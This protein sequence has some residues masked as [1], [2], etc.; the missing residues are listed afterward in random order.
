MGTIVE[1]L[2]WRGD[3]TAAQIP[4]GNVDYLILACLSYARL[5]GIVP[6]IGEGEITIQEAAALYRSAY[7]D[8]RNRTSTILTENIPKILLQ[9]AETRRFGSLRLRNYCHLRDLG[10]AV[11]FSA[12][13]ILQEDGT[14]CISFG[15]TDTSLAG[16]KEDL[17]LSYEVVPA[18]V[19][20]AAYLDTIHAGRQEPILLVGH[21]KGGHLAIYAAAAC[22]EEIRSRITRIFD[23]DGPGFGRGMIEQLDLY[24]LRD[25]IIRIIPV[26]SVI[27][28][29]LEPV[30]EARIVDSTET[31]LMQHYPLSWKVKGGDFVYCGEVDR[32][33]VKA[34]KILE[35]WLEKLD[36]DERKRFIDELFD[37]LGAAGSDSL[38]D[39]M[40]GNL[41]DYRTV[42]AR[43][44]R[45]SE[46]TRKVVELLF[47]VAFDNTIR[48]VM[49][50]KAESLN[51]DRLPDRIRRPLSRIAETLSQDPDWKTDKNSAADGTAKET[52]DT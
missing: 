16:W 11:Q 4:Y 37:I 41:H 28:C 13:E 49:A 19:S 45:A 38:K 17:N 44:M 29:L 27:G 18:E 14:S 39:V 8:I 33:A 7:G 42:A 5:N 36:A 47:K 21:S 10:E 20:A 24:S 30:A 34:E 48:P 22:R 6:W 50:R 2:E 12:V 15:G 43:A 46:E 32:R 25:K 23:A 3:I 26:F 1:Y 52:T 40:R 51:S 9:A 35:E 31:L